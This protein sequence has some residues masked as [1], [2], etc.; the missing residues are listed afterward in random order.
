[1]S[2]GS[3]T[4]TNKLPKYYEDAAKKAAKLGSFVAQQ[5]YVPNVG[6]DVAAL[7]PQ[8]INGMQMSNDW[9]EAF[10]MAP[11]TDVAASIPAAQSFEGG[12]KGYSGFPLAQSSLAELA[13]LYPGLA[14]YIKSFAIDPVTGKLPADSPWGK[15][16]DPA[17]VI[18]G[19]PGTTPPPRG[20]SNGGPGPQRDR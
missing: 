9:A 17:V 5:G 10:G 14:K 12:I 1:M 20:N 16:A 13:R 19:M 18:P 3:T 2:G 8:A 11:H 15:L 7:D 4:Q 6:P